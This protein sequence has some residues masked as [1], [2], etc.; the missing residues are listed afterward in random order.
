M[1]GNS[2]ILYGS[3]SVKTPTAKIG[4]DEFCPCDFICDYEEKVFADSSGLEYKRD[5]TEVIFSK[6][7]PTDTIVFKLY[8]Y[9][10][11]VATLND[12]Q[13]GTYYNGFDNQPL[14]VAYLVD[15]TKVFN[16]FTG[17]RYQI[18]TETNI[19]G[20]ASTVESRYFRLSI[21]SE[22]SANR[23]VK[24]QSIQNGNILR[25]EFDYTDLLNGGWNQFI[26]LNGTFGKNKPTLESDVFLNT[27]YEKIQN[28]DETIN[29]YELKVENIP[30]EI[31][32]RLT[33]D[34][35]LGNQIIVSDYDLMASNKY[36]EL[37]VYVDS[38]SDSTPLANGRMN[39]T[40]LC[41]DRIQ[42]VRKRNF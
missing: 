39:I 32:N 30:E 15:W 28:Q 18:K 8:R 9:G 42:D 20:V 3:P 33:N 1:S 37:P 17:G 14:Y 34:N 7:A 26:R 41:K 12:D 21:W 35:I 13:F 38:I 6:V 31:L 36:V 40:L 24:I 11:E 4:F 2:V 16:E 19:L 27:N 22:L 10:Q 5:Y 23:T 25:S 29:E